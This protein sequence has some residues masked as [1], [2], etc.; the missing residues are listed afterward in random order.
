MKKYLVVLFLALMALL[1]VITP[2]TMAEA[3][4]AVP[5]VPGEVTPTDIDPT[6]LLSKEVLAT[7]TGMILVAGLLTQGVK[8]VFMRQAGIETIRTMAFVV[9]VVV[10]VIAKLVLKSPFEIADVVII[11]GNA[12]V[13]WFASM[14]AYEKT[15]GAAATPAGN[16]PTTNIH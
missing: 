15:L 13:V 1:L 11:P 14:K 16:S 9:S 4:D 8:M 5:E 7:M 3:V 2:L 10:V 12:F 6:Q